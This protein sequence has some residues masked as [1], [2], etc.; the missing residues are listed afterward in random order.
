MIALA[1]FA[2]LVLLSYGSVTL[3][4]DANRLNSVRQAEFQQLQRAVLFIERD[5][6]QLADRPVS[7]GY[8]DEPLP[9]LAVPTMNEGE[10]LAFSRG[11]NSDLAGGLRTNAQMR[12][13]L[14]RVRYVLDED[15]L[16]RESWNVVDSPEGALPVSVLLLAHVKSVSFEFKAGKS[17]WQKTWEG[18]GLPNAVR[19]TLTHENLGEIKRV[20]LVYL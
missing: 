11:G 2:V 16:L 14:Q 8:G 17:G 9:A 13:S 10:L 20:F 18:K 6:H 12:S 5:M 15:K 7:T 4:M 1:I 3:L 19:L